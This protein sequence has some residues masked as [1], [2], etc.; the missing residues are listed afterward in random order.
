VSTVARVAADTASAAFAISARDYWQDKIRGGEPVR[1]WK[2]R[3][4]VAH[5]CVAAPVPALAA[6]LERATGGDP[7]ALLVVGM[8]A[9]AVVAERYTCSTAPLLATSD[10]D[11]PMFFVGAMRPDAT[12]RSLIDDLNRQ[13]EE[14]AQFSAWQPAQTIESITGWGLTV[15]GAS[16][17]AEW[18]HR[19]ELW[20]EWGELDRVVVRS[21]AAA[22]RMARHFMTALREVLLSPDQRLRDIEVLD[23]SDRRRL[24]EE[25]N[26]NATELPGATLAK[27][28]EEQARLRPDAVA[29]IDCTDHERAWTYR[30]LDHAASTLADVLK[31]RGLLPEELVP[32]CE[33]R[34]ASLVT[35]V[36][37]V[38]KAGG[39]YVP[40]DPEWPEERAATVMRDCGAR[41]GLK[42][43]GVEEV[44]TARSSSLRPA[45]AWEERS[46]L[47]YVM[48]TS[49]STG[50]PKG[51]LIEQRAIVR[52]V[53]NTNYIEFG[54]DE[55]ILQTG[56]MAFDAATL[57]IWGALLNGGTLVLAPT[58][59]L[60]DP[61]RLKALLH[62]H[63]ITTVWLTATWCHQLID[64]DLSIFAC[65]RHVLAGG[66]RLSV[67]HMNRLRAAYP[68][69][70]ITN[71]Y[72][73]TENTTFTTC[74][75]IEREYDDD[76][77]I[78]KPVS[79][80]TVFVLDARGRLAPEGA[81]GELCTG[82][83]GVA[84]GYWND[85][86]LSARK[87]IPNR[88]VP[89]DRLY[90]TGDRARWREDGALDFLGRLDD[91]IKLRGFRIEPGEIEAVLERLESVAQVAAAVRD[92][93]LAAWVVAKSVALA[94]DA[95]A[96]SIVSYAASQLPKGMA[97]SRVVFVERIPLTRNGKADRAALELPAVQEDLVAPRTALEARIAAIW[98]E[99]LN[100]KP[101][102]V[103]ADFFDLGGHSLK[104][105]ALIAKLHRDPGI[106][107][108]IRDLYRAPTV[109][110]LAR[111]AEERGSSRAEPI[112]SLPRA[113]Y[114]AASPAQRRLWI[115][116]QLDPGNVAYNMPACFRIEGALDREALAGAVRAL[117]ARHEILRTRFADRAGE[118]VQIVEKT[119]GEL[120]FRDIS[121][122]A[123]PLARLRDEMTAEA[124]RL[125]AL[126]RLPLFRARLYRLGEA[127]HALAV[128]LHHIIGDAWSSGILLKEI[129]ALYAGETLAPLRIQYRDAAAWQN[130]QL[131]SGALAGHL[132]YWKKQLAA[133]LPALDLP[134]DYARP[135][136]QVFD[137][138]TIAFRFGAER[139]RAF[140]KLRDRL[141]RQNTPFSI[142][143]TT[144]YAML[145]RL[146]GQEDLVVG[147][148]VA[149]RYHPDLHDRVGFY[150]NT[151]A[152]R[153][154]VT[155]EESF[156]A[157]LAHVREL[158]AEALD[159]QSYPF[160]RLVDEL[161]VRRDI[162][163]AAVFDVFATYQE[164]EQF[165]IELKGLR[166][167]P[168]PIEEAVAKF[169][170]SFYFS[171]AADGDLVCAIEFNTRL[172]A[173][174]TIER[175]AAH[176][177]A[178]LDDLASREDAESATVTDLELLNA[179]ERRRIL[180]D[181][182]RTTWNYPPHD[183][184]V[185][186]FEA[187]A[188][189]TPERVAI[190]FDRDSLTYAQLNARANR[191]ARYLRAQGV[192]RGDLVAV[193]RE[194]APDTIAAL[195]GVLKAGAAYVPVDLAYPEARVRYLLEDSRA[196]VMLSDLSRTEGE[197]ALNPPVAARPNDLAYI[198]YT[199]GSTGAPKGVAIEHRA[200]ATFLH[201]C[202]E[203]F[204]EDF[205]VVFAGT[206]LCFDLSIFELFYTL[207]AGKRIRL[208][209]SNLEIGEW[210]PREDRIAV[211]TVPS[212][213]KDLVAAKADFSR[214]VA[215]N[216]AGE[217]IPLALIQTL[218]RL[219]P[220]CP[221]RNLYGPSEDTTYS[222]CYRFPKNTR[223]VLVGRA[224]A[225][226]DAYIL[227]SRLR[228][229]PIGV[230]GELYLAGD[231]L[232]REYL[233]KPELTEEKFVPNPF[234]PGARMYRTQDLA[235]WTADGN[236]DFLGRGDDQVKI[237]GFRIELEEVEHAL[238][239]HPL[240]KD[241]AVVAGG[242]FLVAFVAARGSIT[243]EELREFL[244]RMLPAYMI[245]ARFSIVE[246]LPLTPNGK[247]DRKALRALAAGPAPIVH[248]VVAPRDEI[249]RALVALWE[250]VLK[251]IPVGVTDNFFDLG[252]HSLKATRLLARVASELGTAMPLKAFFAAPTVAAQ[253]AWHREQQRPAVAPIPAVAPAEHYALS[254]AQTR[255]WLL[256]ELNPES[257]AYHMPG[258]FRVEG[259]LDPARLG[260]AFASVV[261]RH[262][263]LRARFITVDGAP[264]QTIDA[265]VRAELT[266]RAIDV[267]ELDAAVREA[268]E[269]P[270]NLAVAPPLRAALFQTG[271]E[272]FTLAFVMHHLAAD[273]WSLNLVVE[274]LLAIY[275]G[276]SVAPAPRV[277]Y[278]DYAA[279]IN[280][281]LDCDELRDERRWW[282]GALAHLLP[283]LDLPADFARPAQPGHEG[284]EVAF[285]IPASLAEKW[286]ALCRAHH[287]T[288]FAGLLAAFETLLYRYT[289]QE[290][291]II[292]TP[293]SG[294]VHPDLEKQVG[295]Y[296]NTL[297]LRG[298]LRGDLSFA[299]LLGAA[300]RVALDATAHQV[301]P[302][303]RLVDE[304]ALPRDTARSAV[305]DVMLVV[306]QE[307]AK[308]A[309]EGLRIE[310]LP[311]VAEHTKFD[312]TLYAIESEEGLRCRFVYNKALFRRER[313]ERMARHFRNIM[314]FAVEDA[315]QPLARLELLDAEERERLLWTWNRTAHAH[316][317]ETAIERFER[318]AAAHSDHAAVSG[319]SD[320]VSYGELNA[321]ANRLREWLREIC[322][323]RPGD[324][325]V[326]MLP[327]DE[328]LPEALLAI[329]KAGATY[330]PVDPSN[331]EAR[332]RLILEDCEARVVLREL[333][334]IRVSDGQA[335]APVPPAAYMIYTSGTTGTPKGA[336]Q[337]HRALVNYVSWLNRAWGVG[338][339]DRSGLLSSYAFDLGYT[340]LW[341]TLL[342]G[343]ELVMPPEGLMRDPE[344]TIRWIVDRRLTYVKAT[345]SLFE[346]LLGAP[347]AELFA[348]SD[349]RLV[350]L[351]GEPFRGE[352]ARRFLAIRPGTQFVNHYGPTETTIGSIA[353][354][355]D[356]A[357]T[358][359]PLGRP[360]DNT[361][362][363]IVDTSG[364]PVPVGVPGELWIAGA[365]VGLGYWK[366]REPERFRDDP[367]WLNGERLYSTGDRGRWTGDGRIEF[368]GRID[369][370]VKIRG[371]RV[372]LREV[373][374]RMREFPGARAAAVF[375]TGGDLVG[376]IASADA[377][378]IDALH[379][380]LSER[381]P[382]YMVPSRF[383]VVEHLSLTANGK[384]DTRKLEELAEGAASAPEAVA[385][386]DE[387]EARIAA[388]WREVLR[389]ESAGVRDD[390][391][392]S[393]G[394]SLRAASLVSRVYRE[395]GIS[396][397]LRDF[398][399]SP[400]IEWIASRVRG[401]AH[402]AGLTIPRI[403]DGESY[404]LS[405]A[406]ER[407]W[408]LQH[409]DPLGS[410]YSMPSGFVL[411]GPLEPER[412]HL[413][414]A[415]VAARHET[416]R[417]VFAAVD[418]RPR[419]RVV[420]EAAP[421]V[422]EMDLRSEADPMAA[423]M[424][425]QREDVA[426]SFDLERG[427]LA[428]L[429]QLRTGDEQWVLLLNMHHIVSDGWSMGVF[430]RELLEGY[431]DP[432]GESLPPLDL[433]YRDVAAWQR[434]KAADATRDYWLGKFAEP[435]EPLALSTDRPRPGV[436]SFAGDCFTAHFDARWRERVEALSERCR[437][438][439]FMTLAAGVTAVLARYTGQR[440]ICVGTAI[441]GRPAPELEKLIGFFVGTL[442][443]RMRVAPE[444]PFETLLGDVRQTALDAFDH[445]DYPFD[446]MVDELGA[447]RDLS[448]NPLF[449]VM[450]VL[451]NTE[452]IV[453]D[454]GG[455]RAT[456]LEPARGAS[457]F[458]LNFVFTAEEH[459]LRLELEYATALFNRSRIERL[460]GHLENLLDDAAN[461]PARAVG[462]LRLMS[463]AEERAFYAMARGPERALDGS[464]VLDR[465]ERQAARTPS[466]RALEF[467]G[468][469]M[470]YAELDDCANRFA[471][472]LRARHSL[473]PD[474]LVAVALPRS[475]WLVIALLGVWKADAAWLPLDPAQPEER[476]RALASHARV[477]I[478][479]PDARDLVAA[480][481]GGVLP[482]RAAGPKDPAY[483]L[484]TSGSAGTPKGCVLE[485]GNIAN[486]IDWA[487]RMYAAGEM[488]Y[489]LHSPIT[490]DLTMTSLLCPLVRGETL[491][492]YLADAQADEMLADM[493]D[494]ATAVNF[495]KLTPSHIALLG[496]LPV[497]CS[498]V[499]V[500]VVGG[501][502]VTAAH[503]RT[504]RRLNPEIRFINEYG[505][506]ETAVGSMWY[507]AGDENDGPVSIGRPIQN[508][509]IL[510][511]DERMRPVPEGIPG[512]ICIGGA[513]VA[514]GYLGLADLTDER[515]V[516]LSDGRRVYRTGD[517]GRWHANG[518]EYLG[519]RDGQ[520]KIRGH[521]VE[522]G[523]IEAA[524]MKCAGVKHA[525]A[526]VRGGMLLAWVVAD[527]AG[528]SALLNE[529][530][531]VLPDY[532][533]P[534][535]VV[536]VEAMPV[537]ANGKVDR[538]AL[539]DPDE[540]END[541][542]EEPATERER[543]LAGVWA[544]LLGR[545]RI[546]RRDHF[547][548]LGGDSIRAVQM[549]YRLKEL[550]WKLDV[551]SLF[552]APVLADTAA[553]LEAAEKRAARRA[554]ADVIPLT[555]IQ[556][557]F[558]ATQKAGWNHFNQ[559]AW[560][561]VPEQLD[562]AAIEAAVNRVVEHHEAFRLRFANG[563]QTLVPP[564]E[565]VPLESIEPGDAGRL[566]ASLDIEHGPLVRAGLAGCRLL[567]V[568]H[569]LVVDG[570]SWRI[571]IED[572]QA[573]FRGDPLAPA[574]DSFGAWAEAVAGAEIEAVDAAQSQG[575]A[576]KSEA[577]F[578]ARL[579]ADL[580]GPAGH[581]Y[582]TN[583]QDLLLAA[584]A[585]AI[586]EPALLVVLEGH[587]RDL[588]DDFD[589]SRTVGWFT[590]RYRVEIDGAARDPGALIK[591]VKENVRAASKQGAT[592][593]GISFNYLGQ[594]EGVLAE[595][596]GP[597]IGPDIV[598]TEELS[599][600]AAVAG[601][602]LVVEFTS[603]GERDPRQLSA[604]F[605]NALRALVAH[606]MNAEAE[607]TPS[608]FTFKGMS[609]EEFDEMFDDRDA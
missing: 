342:N 352:D 455:V 423:A 551:P 545:A 84:R 164:Q 609:L 513:G 405:P 106:A 203:E 189:R 15:Q 42:A 244:G 307:R 471:A 46:P 542:L 360:I 380:F 301:Y 172:F 130:A 23:E 559:S 500:A 127:H 444:R 237:R 376:A 436:Q 110:Q 324:R 465:F 214:V 90:R 108:S 115:L 4:E 416:L 393:G 22:E 368:L 394:H 20:V 428:R 71:G 349:L 66:E 606:S 463:A 505:P 34:S 323:V 10:P 332:V 491:R 541:A 448:R 274:E 68:D 266:Y 498:N 27:L 453:R 363:Y 97:P 320:R 168:F 247:T 239:R 600:A 229:A 438:T 267:S 209:R 309:L 487:A 134:A 212:V 143:L 287:A 153:Q 414:V 248:E 13:L 528:E 397:S 357:E 146:S 318:L 596:A 431:R 398:F 369:R 286:S 16:A 188:A 562:A 41:F 43:G 121:G 299:E 511:L 489:G 289:G 231:K 527:D 58:A 413:A 595:D 499:R 284:A 226:T 225:N 165:G 579:T 241:A 69:L 181:F 232:A 50:Q 91:Q 305:F 139:T 456:P 39:A 87:F 603:C 538:N 161:N 138:R 126:D 345:P 454:F 314:A 476:L 59:D 245:P 2:S 442:P 597:N 470:T 482:R 578:D 494:P 496:D 518:F 38:L 593:G 228:P 242:D 8:A 81:A 399:A 40:V 192:E 205:D 54:P 575:P 193:Y 273:G 109:E 125:F 445:A 270:F 601:G 486:Y 586:G 142:L 533:L 526:A 374:D 174:Q 256:G 547:F 331:P 213:V 400:T 3:T 389:H 433:Q 525:A 96:A 5:E 279:W 235:R 249:E 219:A 449:D 277:Q 77:P 14:G 95:L 246:E 154:S 243:S 522:L 145:H 503:V 460:C 396:I 53:R 347:G 24:V 483:V 280:A 141:G 404:E 217:P 473:A 467:A 102:S 351:G 223:R 484:F 272:S 177:F 295:L 21:G 236:I 474:D 450:V 100:R 576:R 290:D 520:V 124:A 271:A 585:R 529:L 150:V 147:I 218:E 32:I 7:D 157:L 198:I 171:Q 409:I 60:L 75:P 430:A 199:S 18:L 197:D 252:G 472:A 439:L 202:E 517:F 65:L 94:G 48:Y 29:I 107:I 339:A 72:G 362:V 411:D 92:D 459:G 79:N 555:P 336:Q 86:E 524:L 74:H 521:R 417:T 418:G 412:F 103:R 532:M 485:H 78:G 26:D 131:E 312:L 9:L 64:T 373:E 566:H 262:E 407:L 52:L 311:P 310:E 216:M 451:Q 415:V 588:R 144:L 251:R 120:E 122:D 210:L 424:A 341:G 308:V 334:A 76:I 182:N 572:L 359:P 326:V 514:R 340:S 215:L 224:V 123:D 135:P 132:A 358:T 36:I 435:I 395:T 113:D 599:V 329:W 587:G 390:F 250:A 534:S 452:P 602:E 440:D 335:K 598:M 546:G 148:P 488:L 372:E 558:F 564:H 490:F 447:A 371:Y 80:T 167:A 548:R 540:A 136:L 381:L 37:G 230:V 481:R 344:A 101:I 429:H 469:A 492:I 296:V 155:A 49:G 543:A 568:I 567:L 432:S 278:K 333:P 137:G 118:P 502:A 163:R 366:D 191:I 6:R 605:A 591:H 539:P 426:H 93:K 375:A 549:S 194:R 294:R 330:V 475:E 493:F 497:G 441:A 28:F 89:G 506:T 346:M 282:H 509:E 175:F 569:H 133:P 184:M 19:L 269:R 281:R 468:G 73:P 140:E 550:G 51:A 378:G 208:L 392:L 382:A 275:S 574:T 553:L 401:R 516:M 419:Q 300:Q 480:G 570:Y 12:P 61:G 283:V 560:I 458:D 221:I 580:S 297:A 328:R 544:A 85:A 186:L 152:L 160:E 56:S 495:V 253:A 478:T 327:A 129:S 179:G 207:A 563:A 268:L 377:V 607:A 298:A 552:A 47:A 315:H 343:G 561:E 178:L 234:R 573:A 322:G 222:T 62:R 159:H 238:R 317:A 276:A 240:V 556:R 55:R 515:F 306:E 30:E 477:T 291:V 17:R 434:G 176:Y 255:L 263:T 31:Q 530:A 408:L 410:A 422:C 338:A 83:A 386:R 158:L 364:E 425:L 190:S 313:V 169:D 523:E 353:G 303:D 114:Y 461:D 584:L 11:G 156:G 149:G 385:P 162:S 196:K 111:L 508:T 211:N 443:L 200:A 264:R 70:R 437:A 512:E 88:F 337:P 45:G 260:H 388:L 592:S 302:F 265:D 220:E 44:A 117:M 537:T 421:L 594:F 1:L 261:A 590:T 319:E 420:N 82:G 536:A 383:A 254:P 466:A 33:D 427:P 535:R 206:S 402:A 35:Q 183:T 403:P 531:R 554:S 365:G 582:N 387:A 581:A 166:T 565:R 259:P 204:T 116:D 348:R 507:E 288:L 128:H 361:R 151:L 355:V 510:I 195:L 304:L 321:R 98:E 292:G 446:Q 464:T 504:L 462:D 185:S 112:P 187:Q 57:E 479:E 406:Q 367:F 519:R 356:A 608:D 180:A 170:L 583:P 350:L 119:A 227:D 293:A 604:Q 104:A 233:H 258:V 391:F 63:R 589:V 201:W 354:A 67:P 571:L 25:Y 285:G 501:E 457:K 379:G 325:V 99:A 384:L 173:A 557:W 257:R 370:Q 105:A 316:P 577:C